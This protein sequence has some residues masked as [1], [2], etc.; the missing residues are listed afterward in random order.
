MLKHFSGHQVLFLPDETDELSIRELNRHGAWHEFAPVVPE[1]GCATYSSKVNHAY[2]VT[3]SPYLLY[4]SD[5]IVPEAKWW[6]S[7]RKTLESNPTIGLLATNDTRHPLVKRGRLAVHG[8]LRRSYIEEYGSASLPDAGPVF[9]EGYR[10][11]N[12]DVEVSYVARARGVFGYDPNSILKHLDPRRDQTLMDSTYKLGRSFAGEDR[13]K[14]IRRCPGWPDTAQLPK[15]VI[16]REPETHVA[17]SE[18]AHLVQ[19]VMISCEQRI[20]AR[21]QTIPQFERIGIQ[22]AISLSPCKPA[23]PAQNCV[24]SVNALHMAYVEGKHC[25]FLEDD[26]DIDPNLFQYFLNRAI[27]ADKV[28]YFYAHDKEHL[29]ESYYGKTLADRIMRKLPIRR[30]LYPVLNTREF[31]NAQAIFLPYWFY[32]PLVERA[33]VQAS[34]TSFDIFLGAYLETVG[35]QALVALPHPVWHRHDRTARVGMGAAGKQSHSFGLSWFTEGE[36]EAVM[37]AADPIDFRAETLFEYERLLPL[38]YAMPPDRKGFFYAE[39]QAAR[40]MPGTASTLPAGNMPDNSRKTITLVTSSESAWARPKK[41]VAFPRRKMLTVGGNDAVT[42]YA[43]FGYPHLLF[44]EYGEKQHSE[45][46]IGFLLSRRETFARYCRYLPEL[47]ES[48]AAEFA[49]VAPEPYTY[50]WRRPV[51]LRQLSSRSN[52]TITVPTS[53]MALL[54]QHDDIPKSSGRVVPEQYRTLGCVPNELHSA[55]RDWFNKYRMITMH[56]SLQLIRAS[57]VLVTDDA[58]FAN[59]AL[60][61]GKI[62]LMMNAN[63]VRLE[64]VAN[65]QVGERVDA[66]EFIQALLEVTK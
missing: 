51:D 37:T 41:S 8:I 10:H 21:A 14:R 29:V 59:E 52:V 46:A 66:N 16:M 25:L 61:L 7:A 60:V 2:R 36:N 30:D 15:R 13:A 9:W 43:D 23:G 65:P 54:V 62:P 31:L 45:L 47:A 33:R 6:I 58:L 1:F 35:E 49:Y 3:T 34:R 56:S 4:A 26:I 32:A 17:P 20:E 42:R 53:R 22:V 19:A 50:R 5:D 44:P 18:D 24:A 28:T 27:E 39:P 63:E 38:W 48:I 40:T 12:C 57:H 55:A 11:W 64:P